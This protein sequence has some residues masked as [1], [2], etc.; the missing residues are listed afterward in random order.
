MDIVVIGPVM[1]LA[2]NVTTLVIKE[3]VFILP[4]VRIQLMNVPVEL[5]EQETVMVRE[6]AAGQLMTQTAEP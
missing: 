1:E 2:C 6:P 4:L 3:L 5:V